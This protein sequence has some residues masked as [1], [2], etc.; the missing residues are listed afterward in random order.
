MTLSNVCSYNGTRAYAQS[1][2]ANILHVK[3]IAR[4]LQARNA[5]VTINA[6]HPGVV[7]TGIIR[8]H[9]GFI[10]GKNLYS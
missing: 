6:V 10:T 7:K 3:E 5:R 8:A 2:L 1:K 9:K 4:Q